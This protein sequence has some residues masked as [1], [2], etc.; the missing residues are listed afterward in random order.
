[1]VV[2]WLFLVSTAFTLAK[3]LRDDHE[4][5]H[6]DQAERNASIHSQNSQMNQE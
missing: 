1:L 3:M 6:A 2:S 5:Q 4:A